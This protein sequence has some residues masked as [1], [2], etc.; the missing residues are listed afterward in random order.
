MPRAATWGPAGARAGRTGRRRGRHCARGRAGRRRDSRESRSVAGPAGSRR[1]SSSGGW[2]SPSQSRPL[3]VNHSSPVPGWK[4]KPTELRTPRA[5]ISGL[6]PPVDVQARD[7][8]VERARQRADVAGSAD[9]DVQ[10]AVGTEGDEL[11]AVVGV[12]GERVAGDL[13]AG[14]LGQVAGDVAEAQDAADGGDVEAAV[15]ERDAAGIVQ[16]TGQHVNGLGAVVTVTVHDCVDLALGPRAD[17]DD[18]ARPQRHLPRV[19]HVVGVDGDA[20][21]GRDGQV[22]GLGG[23]ARQQAGQVAAVPAPDGHRRGEHRQQDDQD[24]A[25]AAAH[26]CH[27]AR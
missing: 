8:G 18:A 15:A 7:R 22:G 25:R 27:C 14:G 13:G 17:E 11:P 10:A 20:E 21:A 3:S 23:G 5:T 2:S 4:S 12:L 26:R 19:R 1:L 6:P 16:A 24:H 9:G